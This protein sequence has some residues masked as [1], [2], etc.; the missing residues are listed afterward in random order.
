MQR[1]QIILISKSLDSYI[2]WPQLDV[3]SI[4]Q[5]EIEITADRRFLICPVLI[6]GYLWL[7]SCLVGAC[8][9]TF[10]SSPDRCFWP[11]CIN[12]Q[13]CRAIHCVVISFGFHQLPPSDKDLKT[14]YQ[15]LLALMNCISSRMWEQQ[16]NSRYSLWKM[17]LYYIVTFIYK[18]LPGPTWTLHIIDSCCS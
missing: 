1:N 3:F 18:S 15:L 5:K 11:W 8:S 2:Q 14:N 12:S 7:Y 4:F 10:S 13:I 17:C 9:P 16:P 6:L